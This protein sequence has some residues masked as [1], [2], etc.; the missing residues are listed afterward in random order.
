MKAVGVLANGG[1]VHR[2]TSIVQEGLDFIDF[3]LCMVYLTMFLL[4]SKDKIS[5]ELKT[6]VGRGIH[7]II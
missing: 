7:D 3:D 4:V 6:D 5:D 2:F 1:K